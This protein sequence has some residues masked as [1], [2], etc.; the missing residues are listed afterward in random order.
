MWEVSFC[1]VYFLFF[2]FEYIRERQQSMSQF[3]F[4]FIWVLGSSQPS[5]APVSPL[6]S[7]QGPF[8]DRFLFWTAASLGAK[9]T[10]S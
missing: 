3:A 1:Q 9:C 2:L 10:T 6:G 7:S 8:K 5:V 4:G